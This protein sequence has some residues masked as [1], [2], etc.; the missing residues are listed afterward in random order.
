MAGLY[1][2]ISVVG[3]FGN[4]F[5][6]FMFGSRKSLRTPANILV[7]N[8][9]I[10]DFLMLIKCPIA[11]YNNIQ[12]GPALGDMGKCIEL[13]YKYASLPQLVPQHMQPVASMDLWADSAAP[14]P[15]E[16]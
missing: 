14:A 4:A 13:N 16:H 8:L 7:M 3:C 12:E 5:V 15:L 9:A 6:I 1:C 11:I 2:L 10:C